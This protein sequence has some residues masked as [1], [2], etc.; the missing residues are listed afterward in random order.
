MPSVKDTIGPKE[1]GPL[2][3]GSDIADSGKEYVT[4]VIMN[5]RTAPRGF[6]S[7]FII[8]FD[9][10]VLP[11][12]ASWGVN[13]TLARFLSDAISDRTENWRGWGLAL[14]PTD[15]DE[16][17][18]PIMNPRTNKPA[19]GIKILGIKNP[20][21]VA[22]TRKSKPKYK[23]ETE[24]KAAPKKDDGPAPNWDNMPF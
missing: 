19:I 15:R 4:G 24:K 6:G 14:A 18:N 13:A 9:N 10:D 5:V 1:G 17:G 22:K 16:K 8:D 21:D 20:N 11:G 23:L 12:I 2:L 7:P 3:H